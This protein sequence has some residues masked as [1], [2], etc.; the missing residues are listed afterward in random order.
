MIECPY[1]QPPGYHVDP[2]SDKSYEGYAWC[3]LPDHPCMLEY[4]G[5]CDVYVEWLMAYL[6]ELVDTALEAR[7]ELDNIM[8]TLHNYI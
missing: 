8:S 2:A 3:Y 4:D 6:E 1:Y 5:K 7:V